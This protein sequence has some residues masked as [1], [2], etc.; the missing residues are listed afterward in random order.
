[1][2]TQLQGWFSNHPESLQEQKVLV[3]TL[4]HSGHDLLDIVGED[5]QFKFSHARALIEKAGKK[6]YQDNCA[7]A[8]SGYS[9]QEKFVKKLLG[10]LWFEYLAQ[11]VVNSRRFTNQ[12]PTG[13]VN[14]RHRCEFG[15]PDLGRGTPDRV[16]FD[17]NGLFHSAQSCKLYGDHTK[18]PPHLD[19]AN[20]WALNE[21]EKYAGALG[22]DPELRVKTSYFSDAKNNST[23]D[24]RGGMVCADTK[25]RTVEDLLSRNTSS[26]REFWRDFFAEFKHNTMMHKTVAGAVQEAFKRPDDFQH[27]RM[28]SPVLTH[29]GPGIGNHACG[30][31][32]TVAQMACIENRRGF[33]LYMPGARLALASQTN[34]EMTKCFGFETHRAYVMSQQ[35]WHKRMGDGNLVEELSHRAGDAMDLA[36]LIFDYT[37]GKDVRP[38][39]IMALE[40]SLIKVARALEIIRDGLLTDRDGELMTW[41]D[42]AEKVSYWW[43][44]VCELLLD[45]HYDEAHNLVTGDRKGEDEKDVRRK[46]RMIE[47]LIWMNALWRRSIYW[48]ATLK[49]N[50]TKYDMTNPEIFGE[51]IACIR[52]KESADRG[53]TVRPFI[54]PVRLTSGSMVDSDL[55]DTNA[56]KELTYYIRAIEDAQQRCRDLGIACRLLIFTNGTTYHDSFRQRIREYFQQHDQQIWCEYVQAG[57][58]AERRSSLFTEFAASDFAVLLNHN[59][60]SEGINIPTC[61][62]VI[63]GRQMNAVTL[64][65]A[66]GRGCRLHPEDYDKLRSGQLKAGDWSNYRKPWGLVYTYVDESSS[67]SRAS[68]EFHQQLIYEMRE[69]NGGDAWWIG[70]DEALNIK[71]RGKREAEYADPQQ[72][73]DPD[74]L[75]AEAEYDQDFARLLIVDTADIARLEN[76]ERELTLIKQQNDVST[77]F[78]A[79]GVK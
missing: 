44:R 72:N 32:K 62:G 4:E 57:T 16:I 69:V 25:G 77:F 53:Y 60:V 76:K 19:R 36:R 41:C 66:I 5:K 39:I 31:G 7:W 18:S 29:T 68:E 1:M 61:S 35:E 20:T 27:E 37:V 22:I 70:P 50:G 2:M 52:P 14:S 23:M 59:I 12:L 6:A 45:A 78:D 24:W 71:P 17:E 48:T 65:Q 55:E 51:V 11:A 30:I 67:D 40:P 46:T 38:F 13:W 43:N 64:I 56:D 49:R 33:Y 79:L 3:L 28:V 42:D 21:A 8:R 58:D 15:I 26:Q 54:I 63:L 34:D 10:S 9:T 74:D 47:Y 75:A 73:V